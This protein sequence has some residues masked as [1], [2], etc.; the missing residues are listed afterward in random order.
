MKLRITCGY[1][2]SGPILNCSRFCPETPGRFKFGRTLGNQFYIRPRRNSPDR[3]YRQSRNKYAMIERAMRFRHDRCNTAIDEEVADSRR[4]G[5]V[6]NSTQ[7]NA[8]S[9]M[10]DKAT[11]P[12]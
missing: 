11:D 2:A 6:R 9:I 8:R 1:R 5:A 3:T 12:R 4:V 10:F 7:R